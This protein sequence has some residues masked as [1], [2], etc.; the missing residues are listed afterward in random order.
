M[1]ENKHYVLGV[2]YSTDGGVRGKVEFDRRWINS[3]GHQFSSKLYASKK[4]SSLDTLYRIPAQNP[5]SDYYYFR[6][7]GH[8]KTDNYDSRKLFG[9]G[10]YNFRLGDWEHRYGLVASWEKFTIGLTHGK[11]LLVYPQGQWTYTS[12]KNRLNPK[13]GYQFRFGL[14]G[15]GK[16]LLSDASVVQANL[17]GRYLQSLGDKNRLVGRMALGATWTDDFDRIPPSMRYFAGGDR[18]IRGYAF[19]NIGSRDAGDNNIGGRY[20]A[21]GSLEYEY[22]FKPDWAVAAFV[23][24]GDA[25]IDD[26]KLRVGAGAGVHW[27]S[28][29]GP[30]K[31][32]VG[33]GFDKQY[34]DKVRLHISIGAELDL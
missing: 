30:I 6:L 15:A 26:F 18:S 33:H 25:F 29:V 9:E 4:N 31:V 24:G 14:L 8:I 5:T 13:D 27:Q 21:V 3:R 34:G 20:L 32:D 22:Y 2:G 7:G 12:T 1:D 19:E 16:G 10:G 23:D 28:P 17:D 11:T